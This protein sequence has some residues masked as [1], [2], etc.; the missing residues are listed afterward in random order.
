MMIDNKTHQTISTLT[1]YFTQPKN[2][3]IQ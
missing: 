1:H 3:N 2:V